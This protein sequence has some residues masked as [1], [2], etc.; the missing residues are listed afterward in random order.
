MS[1][2]SGLCEIRQAFQVNL[3]ILEFVLIFS[4]M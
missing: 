3:N 1:Q 2:V 4:L